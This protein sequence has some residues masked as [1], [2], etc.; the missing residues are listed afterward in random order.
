MSGI[1]ALWSKCSV[2]IFIRKKLSGFISVYKANRCLLLWKKRYTE[3][4]FFSWQRTMRSST[5]HQKLLGKMVR[6]FSWAKKPLRKKR[7]MILAQFGEVAGEE[8]AC[9]LDCSEQRS[10][11]T[12]GHGANSPRPEEKL[13]MRVCDSNSRAC[14]KKE[15][16]LGGVWD[17]WE[18]LCPSALDLQAPTVL[19]STGTCMSLKSHNAL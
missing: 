8:A 7:T 4:C 10:A 13:H 12:K 5:L 1:S 6:E 16:V 11:E 14:L 2:I 9:W 15:L 18:T 19:V 3:I 17:R